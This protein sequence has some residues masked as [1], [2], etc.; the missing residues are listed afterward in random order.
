M[1]MQ[2]VFLMAFGVFLN[3]SAQ[4]CM[5]LASHSPSLYDFKSLIWLAASMACY[6]GAFLLTALV[7]RRL[8]LSSA[9]PIMAGMTFVLV[10]VAGWLIFKENMPLS[11]AIGIVLIFT[12][13]LAVLQ[14][15]S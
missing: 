12:G 4:I 14:E 5:K 8:P 2:G 1:L 3:V 9:G 11:K 7:L 13:V 6:I 15:T 10:A